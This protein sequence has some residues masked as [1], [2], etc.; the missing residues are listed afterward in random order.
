MAWWG[1][2]LIGVPGYLAFLFGTGKWLEYNRRTYTRKP[3]A[4]WKPPGS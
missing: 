4:N 2:V 3:P 1:W